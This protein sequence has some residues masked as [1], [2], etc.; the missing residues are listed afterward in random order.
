MYEYKC[1]GAPEKGKRTKGAKTRS[2]RVASVMQDIIADEAVDGWEYM[3]TDLVPVEEKA[4]I[5]SRP[6]E[7]HRA[8]LVFRRALQTQSRN[9]FGAQGGAQNGAQY[10]D[11]EPYHPSEPRPA[12]MPAYD[13]PP[14]RPVSE[15]DEEFRL[16]AERIRPEPVER[17]ASE[18]A[19][20]ASRS[21][22]RGLS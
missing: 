9:L 16:A 8:V 15:T 21:A 20:P 2:D 18:P 19:A 7:V 13:P 1:V 14:R 17:Q 6:Q 11:P 22:P 10:R 12:A 5:F 3:R 4:G